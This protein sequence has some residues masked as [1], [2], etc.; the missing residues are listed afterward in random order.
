MDNEK[1]ITSIENLSI[2]SPKLCCKT[3]QQNFFIRMYKELLAVYD[4]F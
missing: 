2:E 4:Q 3:K 1:A